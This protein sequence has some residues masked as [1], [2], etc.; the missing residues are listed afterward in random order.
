MTLVVQGHSDLKSR[1]S[2]VESGTDELR[3]ENGLFL[4]LVVSRAGQQQYAPCQP[5]RL[6]CGWKMNLALG[7]LDQSG[8]MKAGSGT[9]G[10]GHVMSASSAACWAASSICSKGCPPG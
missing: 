6:D 1:N 3:R 4:K 8:A 5:A 9:T 10:T 2:A 7:M